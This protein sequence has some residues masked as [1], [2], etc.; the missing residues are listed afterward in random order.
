MYI[1]V[2]CS[3]QKEALV[4]LE[5]WDMPSAVSGCHT[6]ALLQVVLEVHWALSLKI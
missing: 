4:F 5:E 3:G 1:I 6:A 2:A